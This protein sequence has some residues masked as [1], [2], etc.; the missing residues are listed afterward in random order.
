MKNY[1]DKVLFILALIVLGIGAAFFY[2]K[3]PKGG[4]PT[5]ASLPAAKLSGTPYTAIEKPEFKQNSHVWN[6]APEQQDEGSGWMYYVFTPPKIW[7]EPGT[8]WIP[9]PPVPVAPVAYGVHLVSAK[10]ELYRVQ[11]QGT[12]GNGDKNDVINF[13][14]E[15]TGLDFHLKV[16]ETSK[17]HE[18]QVKDLAFDQLDKG[19]GVILKAAKVII[20]DLRNNQEI[21]LTQGEEYAPSDN[22]L[23]ILQTDDPFPA[24]E[25]KVSKNSHDEVLTFPGSLQNFKDDITFKVVALDFAKPSVT[26]VKTYTPAKSSKANALQKELTLNSNP[27]AAAPAASPA[28]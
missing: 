9:E 14:D 20:V 10:K 5:V 28:K 1:Y 8:G 23:Y 22:Q 13:S 3:E 11:L 6:T 17:L 7:W 27:T 19:H 12:S 26:V 15:E 18:V 4:L 2:F 21:T 24:K 16:G 25:W